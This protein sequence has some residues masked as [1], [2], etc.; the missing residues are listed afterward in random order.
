[1]STRSV[2]IYFNLYNS[3]T[4][5]LTN[6]RFM[7]EFFESG[8]LQ[9]S[10]RLISMPFRP[11]GTAISFYIIGLLFS[12]GFIYFVYVEIQEFRMKRNKLDYILNKWNIIECFNLLLFLSVIVIFLYWKYNINKND[13]LINM[14]K[15]SDSFDY[16]YNFYLFYQINVLSAG[17]CLVG[18]IKVFKYLRLNRRLKLLWDT[19]S[20]AFADLFSMMIV[21]LLIVSG[22]ALTGNLIFGQN[23][24][25]NLTVVLYQCY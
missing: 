13:Y 8:F 22:F 9:P 24:K 12:L 11:E 23:L 25:L 16:F 5:L 6:G 19:L 3:N 2:S 14:S 21:S 10:Y 15:E 7:I 20:S 17:C 4:K 1:M 18:F